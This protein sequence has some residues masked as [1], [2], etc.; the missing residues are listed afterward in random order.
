MMMLCI[1]A[2]TYALALVFDFRLRLRQSPPGEKALYL[3]LLAISL[4]PLLLN[5]LGVPVPSPAKPI[6]D[7]V[8]AVFHVP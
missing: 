8:K 7:A 5:A 3:A 1:L 2:A 4:V 6:A